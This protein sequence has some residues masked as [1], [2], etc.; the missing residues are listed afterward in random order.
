LKEIT[1]NKLL[2]VF[3]EDRKTELNFLMEE[4]LHLAYVY[5]YFSQPL[6]FTKFNIEE[7]SLRAFF[8]GQAPILQEISA[9]LKKMYRYFKEAYKFFKEKSDISLPNKE[10][11]QL[12]APY[13]KFFELLNNYNSTKEALLE[14]LAFIQRK[15]ISIINSFPFYYPIPKTS[16][17]KE[18]SKIHLFIELIS[19]DLYDLFSEEFGLHYENEVNGKRNKKSA[20]FYWDYDPD[21]RFLEKSNLFIFNSNFLLPE[22]QS[23]WITLFHEVFHFM[24]NKIRE[25]YRPNSRQEKKYKF[26]YDLLK[27]IDRCT[28]TIY[29]APTSRISLGKDTITDIFIDSILVYMFKELYFI[30]MFMNVFIFDEDDLLFPKPDRTWL[31]RLKVLSTILKMDAEKSSIAT[32]IAEESIKILDIY[33][34]V[35]SKIGTYNAKITVIQENLAESVREFCE[36]YLRRHSKFLNELKRKIESKEWAKAYLEAQHMYI[37][38]K[39]KNPKFSREGRIYCYVLHK[40]LLG[41]EAK[42]K[43]SLTKLEIVNFKYLKIRY[44]TEE[45]ADLRKYKKEFDALNYGIYT[46]LKVRTAY[47]QKTSK[48]DSGLEE[49]AFNILSKLGLLKNNSTKTSKSLQN[50]ASED[51]KNKE[52]NKGSIESSLTE[53]N[54][55][56]YKNDYVLTCIKGN[57]EVC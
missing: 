53:K 25:G 11:E 37:E 27:Y 12:F 17:I 15:Y 2:Q 7:H 31:I 38:E 26:I 49:E 10:A 47:N 46:G 35:Q 51:G 13:I 20:Y 40:S 21:L 55:P 1:D 24:V 16:S 5:N 3:L 18:A 48:F 44:D 23:Y 29:I 50:D 39:Y 41:L 57:R 4:I 14:K 42:D 30:P 33:K 52:K 32:Q 56:F 34:R 45:G 36:K 43:A 19:Q 28:E 6:N 54:I 9:D 8:R 22:K